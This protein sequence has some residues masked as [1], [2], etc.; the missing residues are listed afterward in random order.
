MS[1]VQSVLQPGETIRH[2]ASIHWIVYWPGAVLILAALIVFGYGE[3]ATLEGGLH[4]F[5]RGVAGLFGIIGLFLLV[6]EWF[7]WWTTEIAVTN[8]RIIYKAGFIRRNTVEMHMDK[9]ES[10]DV[11]QSILGRLLDYGTVNVRGVGT[12]FEPLE[13][14]AAPIALRNHITGV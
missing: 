13:T 5:V 12:G 7:T 3:F 9:V 10:V 11:D 4:W 14:I 6:P 2:T 1:Y 8:L